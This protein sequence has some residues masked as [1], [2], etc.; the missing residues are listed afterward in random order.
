MSVPNTNPPQAT[1]YGKLIGAGAGVAIGGPLAIVLAR[2][3]DYVA[4]GFF[5]PI[6]LDA[7]KALIE[8]GVTM[9][10]V[11]YAPHNFGGS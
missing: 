2:F 4:P 8:G 5:D 1:S 9:A 3:V 11:Y 7:F 10:G 6:T